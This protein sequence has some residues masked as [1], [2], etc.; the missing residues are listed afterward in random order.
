MNPFR[1]LL[2]KQGLE[3]Y[4]VT[5]L[6]TFF[7]VGTWETQPTRKPVCNLS[8]PLHFDLKRTQRQGL[9]SKSPAGWMR[10]GEPCIVNEQH[11]PAGTNV[12]FHWARSA[13]LTVE[14]GGFRS[15]GDTGGCW[16]RLWLLGLAR[17]PA[18]I[19]WVEATNAAQRSPVPR[20]RGIR[21]SSTPM[22]PGDAG[23]LRCHTRAGRPPGVPS[24]RA[25]LLF[26]HPL[27]SP[28]PGQT[29]GQRSLRVW[30]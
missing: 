7:P 18:G 14:T 24:T 26:V 27:A 30:R 22:S 29:H 11:L 9:S 4:N 5:Q 28:C 25:V 15:L 12:I 3:G 20:A 17:G 16:G 1:N 23:Q 2:Y 6:A 13:Q 21:A 19:W 10:P 8:L